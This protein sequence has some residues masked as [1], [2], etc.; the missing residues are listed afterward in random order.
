MGLL[1]TLTNE[2]YLVVVVEVLHLPIYFL[3]VC[4]LMYVLIYMSD[5][6]P[7]ERSEDIIDTQFIYSSKIP[8]IKFRSSGM[9]KC[10]FIFWDI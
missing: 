6:D 4:V 5:T 2:T 3:W 9:M 10:A 1:S 8:G 7:M